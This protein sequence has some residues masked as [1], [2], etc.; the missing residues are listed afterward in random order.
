MESERVLKLLGVALDILVVTA[1]VGVAYMKVNSHSYYSGDVRSGQS[2]A[3]IANFYRSRGYSL[4]GGI[5]GVHVNGTLINSTGFVLDSA[6]ATIYFSAGGDVFLVYSSDQKVKDPLPQE[7]DPLRLTLK[8]DRD[9]D[10]LLVSL[11]PLWTEGLDD[12]LA[13]VGEVVNAVSDAGVDYE[14][15]VSFKLHG[16]GLSEAIRRNEVPIYWLQSEVN[17]ECS[18]LFLFVGSTVAPFYLVVE[19]MNWR[20]LAKLDSI[21]RTWL[22]ADAHEMLAYDVRVKVVFDRPPTTE[23]KTTIYGAVSSLEGVRYAKFMV[24]F[25]G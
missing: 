9:V 19:N 7:V 16:G 23:E 6:R 24:E 21:L 10:R 5:L 1:A 18:G 2:A 17:E 20:D 12:L 13:K 25:K 22:P 8:V 14:V 11:D 15:F 3:Y 4:R